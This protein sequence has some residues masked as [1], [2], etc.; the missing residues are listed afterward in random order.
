MVKID[1]YGLKVELYYRRSAFYFENDMKQGNHEAYLF[2]GWQY[3]E[4]LRKSQD[5]EKVF[6][7]Y[8]K[9]AE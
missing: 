1:F 2:L 5:F 4:E 8:V 9:G 6:D 7:L 3:S